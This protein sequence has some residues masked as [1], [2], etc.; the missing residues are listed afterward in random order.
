MFHKCSLDARNIA[1]LR[2][3]SVNIPG[4]NLRAGWVTAAKTFFSS[5][6]VIGT[7]RFDECFFISCDDCKT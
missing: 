7:P 6:F 1:T 4:I 3:Q 2:E 5:V